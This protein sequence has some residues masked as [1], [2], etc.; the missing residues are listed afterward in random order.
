MALPDFVGGLHDLLLEDAP[1]LLNDGLEDELDEH[2]SLVGAHRLLRN[3]LGRCIVVELT[4]HE[5][6]Q[7]LRVHPQLLGY[8]GHEARQVEGPAVVGR[9]EGHVP[10]F[11]LE[12]VDVLLPFDLVVEGASREHLVH[13]H[14]IGLDELRDDGVDLLDNLCHLH[15]DLLGLHAS[16]DDQPVDLIQDQAHPHVLVPGLLDHGVGLGGDALDHVHNHKRPVRHAEGAGHFGGEV[17]VA[18]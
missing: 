8:V 7:A 14:D 11:G 15:V 16:L 9:G 10:L 2:L 12:K 17:N 1:V 6:E 3:V 18:G 13:G 4:P 5:L